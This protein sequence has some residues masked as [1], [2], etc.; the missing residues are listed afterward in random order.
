MK[1]GEN[2]EADVKTKLGCMV[3]CRMEK[4]GIW[5]NG[6]VDVVKMEERINEFPMMKTL[7]N[8]KEAIQE[9]ATMKGADDCNSAFEIMK[10]LKGKIPK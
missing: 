3:L 1:T 7:P 8:P 6:G 2:L 9:C 10:C 5:Q 4:C